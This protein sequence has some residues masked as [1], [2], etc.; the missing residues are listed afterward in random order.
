MPRRHVTFSGMQGEPRIRPESP[1]WQT[2]ADRH[3]A[4]EQACGQV[5]VDPEVIMQ[6]AELGLRGDEF[7]LEI[8]EA[9]VRVMEARAEKPRPAAA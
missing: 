2:V 7:A 3:E 5:A 1:L 6:L 9:Y 4:Y 8:A